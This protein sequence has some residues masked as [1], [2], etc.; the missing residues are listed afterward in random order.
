MTST[1]IVAQATQLRYK[2]RAMLP[3][4]GEMLTL[5]LLE[6]HEAPMV[7][8]GAELG[9]LTVATLNQMHA[10]N[11]SEALGIGRYEAAQGYTRREVVAA[12]IWADYEGY[13]WSQLR[14]RIQEC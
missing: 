7:L 13:T 11:L 3:I 12:V 6:S 5:V 4:L 9:K 2:N 1:C 10:W 14:V 8:F